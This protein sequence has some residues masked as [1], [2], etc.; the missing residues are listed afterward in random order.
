[1]KTNTSI[2]S[3]PFNTV[4]LTNLGRKIASFLAVLAFFGMSG[5]A[6]LAQS[7]FLPKGAGSISVSGTALS[8][9]SF[10]G[11]E[12]HLGQYRSYG[13]MQVRYN[14][15]N[16]E[17]AGSGIIVFEAANGDKLV[18][19][20]TLQTGANGAGEMTL[21]WRDSV[22][23]SDGTVVSS[24]GSFSKSKPATETVPAKTKKT[25]VIAIIAILI[26]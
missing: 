22:R 19:A 4:R 7:P 10:T 15:D 21:S 3:T 12:A 13:E 26:G 20:V 18:G 16:S 11:T 6:T 9:F 14:R 25:V 2:N 17:T 1:M 24:S 23:F 8:R 5:R